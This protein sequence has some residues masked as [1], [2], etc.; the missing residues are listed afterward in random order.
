MQT[1][2]E[3]AVYLNDLD[4]FV[5]VQNSRGDTN[6]S[7][8]WKT[9]RRAR[10]FLV[11][12]PVVLFKTAEN[13]YNATPSLFWHCQTD[14]PGRPRVHS[15]HRNCRTPRQ[16]ILRKVQQP[17]EVHAVEHGETCCMIPL[18]PKK[19]RGHRCSTGHPVA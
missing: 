11:S 7:I 14:L 13:T 3:A 16:M 5:T 8:A 6:S 4:L 18:K 10:I 12:R 9:L 2:E 17:H 15:S 19:N 1:H